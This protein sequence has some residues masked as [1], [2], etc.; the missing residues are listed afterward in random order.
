MRALALSGGAAFGAYQVGVWLE[1]WERGW[2]PDVVTGISIGAVNG[3]LLSRGATPD[4]LLAVW[5][6]WPGEL[7]SGSASRWRPPW[8]AQT[9]MF[10]AWIERI[11]AE[12]GP[13]PLHFRYRV[14]A[15]DALTWRAVAF[16][17]ERVD[18]RTLLAACALPG[19]LPPVRVDGRLLLDCGAIR[20][21]PLKEALEIGADEL[22]AVDL[23]QRHPFP[24]VR[25]V[26]VRLLSVLDR[27][28]GERSEPTAKDLEG[29]SLLTIGHPKLLG[30]VR[31]SFRWNRDFVDRLLAQGRQ[32][33]AERLRNATN[34]AP[35]QSSSPKPVSQ[36]PKKTERGR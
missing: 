16:E 8:S 17:G 30:S 9:P 15:L 36:P 18:A 2:R 29:L 26:R 1:L 7:L 13:R 25:W 21:M 23:L 12:F 34:V 33:A 35:A 3:F 6:E 4:E 14:V 24:P 32:D 27:I 5:R 28:H 31:E 19:V 22:I 11:A 10:R 20:Y